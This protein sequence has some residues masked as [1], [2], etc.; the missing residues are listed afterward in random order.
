MLFT[1][2]AH[3]NRTTPPPHVTSTKSTV[4]ACSSRPALMP[5]VALQKLLTQLPCPQET[6]HHIHSACSHVQASADAALDQATHS[7]ATACLEVS[8]LSSELQ[9]AQ[10]EHAQQH[11]LLQQQ[12]HGAREELAN[13]RPRLR[14]EVRRGMVYIIML[15]LY[16]AVLLYYY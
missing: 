3:G 4:R 13:V 11:L 12:L 10:E 8:T 7:L 2:C 14:E 6:S 16:C 5:F 15:L 1:W 9:T